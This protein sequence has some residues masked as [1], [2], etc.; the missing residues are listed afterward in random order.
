MTTV[1]WSLLIDFQCCP[2]GTN[3]FHFQYTGLRTYVYLVTRHPREISD[4]VWLRI[5]QPFDKMSWLSIGICLMLLSITFYISF[6]I[7]YK[8][9]PQRLSS[10]FDLEY[11]VLRTMFGLTEPDDITSINA[12]SGIGSMQIKSKSNINSYLWQ[13]NYLQCPMLGWHFG[14]WLFILLTFEVF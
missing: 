10:K 1:S 6:L 2:L 11:V 8:V 9:C 3:P 14:F 4:N 7:Y 12:S 5:I 13:V